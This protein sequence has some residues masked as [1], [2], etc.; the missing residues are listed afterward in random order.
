MKSAFLL[1]AAAALALLAT[2][3]AA[4]HLGINDVSEKCVQIDG[5]WFCPIGYCHVNLR[6]KVL[7]VLPA[8]GRSSGGNTVIVNPPD[9]EEPGNPPGNGGGG[10]KVHDDNGHGNDPGK[11]DPSNPGKSKD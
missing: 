5:E 11:Y 8:D 7:P 4:R 1:G 10:G 6:G 3:A 9:D 2:P